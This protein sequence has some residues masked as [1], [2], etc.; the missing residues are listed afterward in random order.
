MTSMRLVHLS[1]PH[2]GTIKPSAMKALLIAMKVLNP[3]AIIMSGDITQRAR[4]KQFEEARIFTRTFE[5]IP[6][7]VMPGNHDIPMFNIFGRFFHPYFGFK[8]ILKGQ[9]NQELDLKKVHVLALNS[10]RRSRT[11]QGEIDLVVLERRLKETQSDNQIRIVVFHHPMDCPKRVDE[12]NLLTNRKE[13]MEILNRYD[14]DVVLSGHIHDPFVC[15]SQHRYPEIKR[16]MIIGV[17]GT[18]LSSR[19]RLDANNSFNLIDIQFEGESPELT[20]SRYDLV[21][22]LA[23]EAMKSHRF[24]KCQD[25]G[26]SFN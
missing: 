3:D 24:I 21:D 17:A 12:K 20:I 25:K 11:I 14:V 13:V 8:N 7:L 1:D 5:H 15:L 2:F 23:F 18:C 10:T 9:L 19:T 4:A 26:W 6:V 16:P 22:E